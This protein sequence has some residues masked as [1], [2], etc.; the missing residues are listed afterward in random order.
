M[1]KTVGISRNKYEFLQIAK[2]NLDRKKNMYL[3]IY[4]DSNMLAKMILSLKVFQPTFRIK[5]RAQQFM[6]IQ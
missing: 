3:S 4:K 1:K 2:S 6:S 5:Q